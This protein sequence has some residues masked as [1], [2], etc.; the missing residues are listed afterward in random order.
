MP[1]VYARCDDT[2]LV[3]HIFSEVFEAP[4]E[5]DHLLKEGEGDECVHVQS[6]YQLYDKWGRHNYIWDDEAGDM[7]ELTEDEKPP[8][9]QP[10]PSEVEVLRQQVEALLAQVNILTG[11][12]N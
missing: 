7:R 5:T 9:P 1:K 12:A 11:G 4:E 6:Q 3:E 2:G 10:Q 8:K